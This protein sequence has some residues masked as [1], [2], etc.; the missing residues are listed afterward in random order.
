M[1]FI[2]NFQIRTTSGKGLDMASYDE[3]SQEIDRLQ[4]LAVRAKRD[5]SKGAL[6]EVKR[7]IRLHGFTADDLGLSSDKAPSRSKPSPKKTKAKK[8]RRTPRGPVAPKYR[9]AVTNNT[10]TG[11]GKMPNWLRDATNSGRSLDEFL[12]VI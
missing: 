11:R 1:L 9:D 10:W 8:N 3:L 5:E 4:K 6:Q 7:L 2:Q 12:I